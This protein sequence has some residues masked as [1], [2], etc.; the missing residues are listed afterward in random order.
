MLIVLVILGLTSMTAWILQRHAGSGIDPII[1]DK[2]G[3]RISGWWLLFSFVAAAELLGVGVV[4]FL[5]GAMSF[6]AMREFVTLTP[7][8]QAD[9]RP[10]FLIFFFCIPLQYVFVWLRMYSVYSVLI[11]CYIF[12]LIPMIIAAFGDTKFYLTRITQ[13][14]VSLLICVYSLSFAPAL[15][16]IPLPESN[17]STAGNAGLLCFFL[18]MTQVSEFF[19]FF[20]NY[21]FPV[22]H[23]I[24]PEINT[25]KTWEGFGT[26]L[27]GTALV[28]SILHWAT[29]FDFWAAGLMSLAIAFMAF[30]GTLTLSAIKRDRG[31]TDYGTLVTGHGGI[32]DRIDSICFAAPVFYHLTQIYF[33][34]FPKVG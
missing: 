11:P 34:F 6:W 31:V 17:G 12:L 5:F 21:V 18:L 29:P 22:Q 3:S 25:S 16:T 24:A 9:H 1:L 13:I 19:P 2:F 32:L 30:G 33:H 28:G 26:S 8:R 23:S 7:T 15:L 27:L 14:S 4:V 10:L 20:C